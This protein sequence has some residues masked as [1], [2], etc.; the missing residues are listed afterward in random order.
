M[1]RFIYLLVFVLSVS[2]V[3]FSAR[4]DFS[5][6]YVFG[7]TLSTTTDPTTTNSNYYYGGRDSNGRAW[8]EVLA[9]RQGMNYDATKNDSYWDHNSGVLV[10][11]LNSFQPPADVA[12][13]LFIVWVCNADT[14]D[15]TVA[16]PALSTAQWQATNN[17]AQANHQQIIARLYAMGARNL[18]MPNAVDISKIP[19]FNAGT[20]LTA[21]QRAGCIDY[22]VKLSKTISRAMSLYPGLNIYTPDY[23]TLLNNALTN[24]A[25][26]G[27]TNALSAKGFSIDALTAL[28]IK[29]A[30]FLG[31]KPINFAG[32][33]YIFWDNENPTAK[34]HAI[35]ADVTQQL[36]SPVQIS[37]VTPLGSYDQLD[38]LNV[39]VGLNGFIE[40]MTI[41]NA[42]QQNW[43]TLQSFNSTST[44]Q[45]LFVVAPV[46]PPFLINTNIY[47]GGPIDLNPN[48]PGNSSTNSTPQFIQVTQEQ[49]YRL[50]FPYAWN[51]P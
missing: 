33:N 51:W 43:T 2:A 3:V 29:S 36:L 35:M 17:L 41:T 49:L 44:R 42:T 16:S 20:T 19:V 28:Y 24:A 22:N 31:G 50:R 38:L 11:E 27:L 39:P 46:F 45:S 21:A 4:A 6:L 7:D 30:P 8:V 13:A 23:F 34:F 9:Q 32:T 26:Y 47:S 1:K 40:G 10:N 12:T 18:V 5:S 37:R 48:D 14:F 25:Y 15:A